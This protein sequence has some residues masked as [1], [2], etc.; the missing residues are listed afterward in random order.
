MAERA[1]EAP[2][3]EA[4]V[5]L[6]AKLAATL[7]RNAG[8][9]FARNGCC[10]VAHRLAPATLSVRR[11]EAKESKIAPQAIPI[12]TPRAAPSAPFEPQRL[13]GIEKKWEFLKNKKPV[14][15]GGQAKKPC[16]LPQT[17]LN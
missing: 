7:R 1:M 16:L 3:V 4:A 17:R 12:I 5:A 10:N 14:L 2:T 9:L 15:G 13:E 6:D 8:R 11:A